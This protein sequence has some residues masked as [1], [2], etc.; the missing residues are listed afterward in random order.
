MQTW[1]TTFSVPGNYLGHT[2]VTVRVYVWDIP[3]PE[4][5]L[6]PSRM[7]MQGKGAIWAQLFAKPIKLILEFK[8]IIFRFNKIFF[9]FFYKILALGLKIGL[10]FSLK[11]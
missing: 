3:N 5:I 6:L 10:F 4:G 1:P 7:P 8:L 11:L 9:F 2:T